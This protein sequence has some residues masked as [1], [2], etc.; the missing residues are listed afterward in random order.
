[1]SSRTQKTQTGRTLAPIKGR[2]GV[3]FGGKFGASFTVMTG[4]I[5]GK[6]LSRLKVRK[7]GYGFSK[8]SGIRATEHGSQVGMEYRRPPVT[9]FNTY[10]LE[11]HVKFHVAQVEKTLNNVLDTYFANHK[12]SEQETPKLT[13]A[14]AR[15][16]T[17][18]VKDLGF[19]R[20]RIIA[21][22][23]TVQKRLQC[24]NNAVAFLWDQDRDGYA[25]VQRE[26]QSVFVQI[27][28][29][30]IYLD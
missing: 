28:V 9:Y 8:I 12:Y 6:S 30:G 7:P 25:N 3:R 10:Q 26:V 17:Q 29:F 15:A 22:V 27:T 1:M 21:V 16:T 5:T 23:S 19:N 13:L 18:S 4:T 24:Y 14:M 11:P 20:Y 2:S